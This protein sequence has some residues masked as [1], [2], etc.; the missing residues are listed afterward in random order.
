MRDEYD[1]GNGK[2]GAVIPSPGKTRI[3]IM[4]DDDVIEFFRMKAD[5]AG[6][7]YQTEINRILREY[8]ANNGQLLTLDALRQII[9]EELH[10][11]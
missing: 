3:T 7:G 4:I 9:R 5:A 8:M 11:A 1:F 6:T 10:A 2:R